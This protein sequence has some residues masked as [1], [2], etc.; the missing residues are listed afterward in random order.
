MSERAITVDIASLARSS[1]MLHAIAEDLAMS[2]H[3]IEGLRSRSLGS[4]NIDNALNDFADH[5][6]FGWN[7]MKAKLEESSS[8]LKR[9]VDGY[10]STEAAIAH[11][12]GG[13]QA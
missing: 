9:T 13:P 10:R 1:Q 6:N 8:L 5:W 11:G 2:H 4:K 12:F 7:Q 3:R